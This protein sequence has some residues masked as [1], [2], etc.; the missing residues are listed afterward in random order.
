MM[1]IVNYFTHRKNDLILIFTVVYTLVFTV[2]GLLE[3]NLEFLYYTILMVGLICFV[4][5]YNLQL[6]LG[7]FIVMNL[8][9]LGFMHLLGGN[10]YVEGIRLYDRF[11]L[12]GVLRYDNIVHAYG[13]FIATLALYSLIVDFIDV[14]LRRHYI[15]FS[16]VL[17]LMAIGIGTINELVE[18]AAVVFLGAAEQ[19]GDYFNNALDLLFNTIGSIAACL[20]IYVYRERP[21]FYQKVADKLSERS[22]GTAV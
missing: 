16:L 10:H 14:R 4:L 9:I 5:M 18:F 11:F 1:Y 21:K 15:R 19:V 22:G 13:T 8:S 17:V 3:R 20:I 7:F 12:D 2:N 6:H